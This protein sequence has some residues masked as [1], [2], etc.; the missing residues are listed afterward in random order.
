MQYVLKTKHAKNH[1][2]K[3]YSDADLSDAE[4]T[5]TT[6]SPPVAHQ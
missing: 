3:I 2:H 6:S 5:G 4:S 1:D